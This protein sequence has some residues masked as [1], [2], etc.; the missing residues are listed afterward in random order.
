MRCARGRPE[1]NLLVPCFISLVEVCARIPMF[2][3]LNSICS[4]LVPALIV[5][6]C[7]WFC[8]CLMGQLDYLDLALCCFCLPCCQDERVIIISKGYGWRKADDDRWRKTA[9]I[10]I[11]FS[12][13]NRACVMIVID[14]VL[15]ILELSLSTDGTRRIIAVIIMES[16]LVVAYAYLALL[17]SSYQ[18]PIHHHHK[19]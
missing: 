4:S 13:V 7:V 19:K 2:T 6:V 10:S 8:I 15:S 18:Y 14:N 11:C 1:T 9:S 12:L 16:T 5:C 17:A 3:C